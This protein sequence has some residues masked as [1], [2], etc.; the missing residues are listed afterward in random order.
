MEASC[1]KSCFINWNRKQRIVTKIC[2]SL[3]PIDG[4]KFLRLCLWK[5]SITGEMDREEI[6]SS[7]PMM[8]DRQ[9]HINGEIILISNLL[10][11]CEPI[12]KLSILK[13][14]ALHVRFLNIFWRTKVS[15]NRK[16][17]LI[18]RIS[19]TLITC[20]RATRLCSIRRSLEG[21]IRMQHDFYIQSLCKYSP[22]LVIYLIHF[23]G[24]YPDFS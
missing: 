7:F 16:D 20:T 18:L 4:S 14:S 3:L 5:L 13:E 6:I 21:C 1:P 10:V 23:V 2:T 22:A 19:E 9:I 24:L 8:E 12:I 11:D 15:Y 17:D